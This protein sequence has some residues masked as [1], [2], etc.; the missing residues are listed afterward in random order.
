M[1]TPGRAIIMGRYDE[2]TKTV[3]NSDESLKMGLMTKA[4]YERTKEWN[5]SAGADVNGNWI[6]FPDGVIFDEH[7]CAIMPGKETVSAEGNQ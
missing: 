7:G 4:E 2:K 5:A 3:Y 1:A 6:G